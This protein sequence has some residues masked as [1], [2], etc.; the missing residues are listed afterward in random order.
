MSTP[1]RLTGDRPNA[2]RPSGLVGTITVTEGWLVVG[3]EAAVVIDVVVTDVVLAAVVVVVVE[4]AEGASEVQ[5]DTN[6]NVAT[7]A[8]HRP[9]AFTLDFP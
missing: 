5:P 8:P 9:A 7:R 6:I 3:S 4:T 2:A 1:P